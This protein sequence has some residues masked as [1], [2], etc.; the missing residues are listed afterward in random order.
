MM[1]IVLQACTAALFLMSEPRNQRHV[2]RPICK[3]PI[4][5]TLDQDTIDAITQLH[6]NCLL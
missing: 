1:L 4:I 6:R 3:S 2:E 5:D